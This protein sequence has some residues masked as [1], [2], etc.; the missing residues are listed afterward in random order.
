MTALLRWTALVLPPGA[1]PT[2][3]R[4]AALTGVPDLEA[5]AMAL[6]RRCYG[7]GTPAGWGGRALLM[8]ARKARQVIRHRTA[9]ASRRSSALP[10][11]NPTTGARPAPRVTL[12]GWAR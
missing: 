12:P 4:L 2:A 10:A 5:E 7:S 8:A 1:P 6:A 3:A 11:L 9:P